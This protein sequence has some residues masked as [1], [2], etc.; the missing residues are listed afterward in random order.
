MATPQEQQNAASPESHQ[1][2]IHPSPTSS[3]ASQIVEDIPAADS[4]ETLNLEEEGEREDCGTDEGKKEDE[5]GETSEEDERGFLNN[6]SQNTLARWLRLSQMDR[7]DACRARINRLTEFTDLDWTKQLKDLASEVQR[8]RSQ[9]LDLREALST[10]IQE[11]KE[12]PKPR[13]YAIPKLNFVPWSQ[14]AKP[15]DPAD[16]HAAIDVSFNEPT[17]VDI[18]EVRSEARSSTDLTTS[19]AHEAPPVADKIPERIRISSVRLLYFLDL[20]F[21]NGT[22]RFVSPEIGFYILRPFKLVFY[23]EERI[24]TRIGE[25]EHLRRQ[26]KEMTEEEYAEEFEKNPIP[27]E[28]VYHLGAEHSMGISQLTGFINDCRCLTT[29]FLDQYLGPEI[30]R[31]QQGPDAVRFVDLWFLFPQGSLIYCKDHNIPQKLWK[32]VQRTGGRRYQR[33]PESM[34]QGEYRTVF[35]PFVLDCYFLDYDGVRFVQTYHQFEITEYE[36]VQPVK[37]LSILPLMIAER[38]LQLVNRQALLHRAHQFLELSKGVNHRYYSGRS[39]GMTPDGFKLSDLNDQCPRNVS[40]Y[41]ERIDSE[42][43]IDFSRAFQEI[44]WWRPSGNEPKFYKANIAE[45]DRDG[46]D[47]DGVWDEKLTNDFLETESRKWRSWEHWGHGPQ[48]ES[49]L[50]LLP[51]RVFAFVLR[52]RKWASIQLGSGEDGLKRISELTRCE[53]PWNSLELPQGHKEILQSL[54]ASHFSMGKS[55]SVHFDAVR[56]KGKGVIILLHGVPGIGKTSTAECAAES[57]GRPLLPITCGDLGLSPG[58]VES[59]LQEIFRL[60]QAWNCILL[61]DEADIFLAQRTVTD[62]QR[63]ALVSVFLRTLEYY[64]G[65]LFLTTNRVGVFDEA[66]KSRIHISLYYPPLERLQ[67]QRI[68]QSHIKKAL[69][70]GILANEGDLLAFAEQTF[71]MQSRPESGPVW[72]GRQIRNAFQSA[73]ALAGFYSNGE[74]LIRLQPKYFQSVFDVSDKFNNYIWKTKQGQTD[75][76]WNK[77]LMTRRDDFMYAPVNLHAAAHQAQQPFLGSFQPSTFGTGIQSPLNT[78]GAHGQQHMGTSLG[79]NQFPPSVQPVNNM[80]P[81]GNSYLSQPAA[82]TSQPLQQTQPAQYQPQFVTQIPLHTPQQQPQA[83]SQLNQPVQQQ[84]QHQASPQQQ[85]QNP[86][87]SGYADMPQQHVQQVPASQPQSF[88]QSSQ[89]QQGFH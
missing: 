54:I 58:E 38:D 67:T 24:R 25:F 52:S 12:E 45:Y 7:F 89:G 6:I 82:F 79:L 19:E 32:V 43:I 84:S 80:Q 15:Q 86:Q 56:D 49:D 27:D 46:F 36:G 29:Q 69:N 20:G 66:F 13:R 50:L 2:T 47:R 37:G 30:S 8:C 74:E 57:S 85:A 11:P 39:N 76:D 62:M 22:L 65:I 53:E 33:R 63:N 1:Q 88:V 14:L 77:M 21:C 59:K 61:L 41:S 23:L 48:D 72:N 64:E 83:P 5:S 18:L 17:S 4:R 3:V 87:Y 26:L 60:A 9:V 68:W 44:P 71:N 31:L 35:S 70:A 10:V 40:H 34:P 51:D 73:V 81:M 75:A 42:V 55:K 78:Y 28:E 16:V